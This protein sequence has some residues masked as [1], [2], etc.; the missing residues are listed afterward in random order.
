[1]SDHTPT[2]TELFFTTSTRDPAQ[3]DAMERGFFKAVRLSNGT[4]KTTNR[5]RLDDLNALVLEHLPSTRPL[6]AMDVAVSSG[7]SALEWLESMEEAGIDCRFTAG[8]AAVNAYLISTRSGLRALVDRNGHVLQ[9]EVRGKAVLPSRKRHVAMNIGAVI[10]LKI[11]ARMIAPTLRAAGEATEG[12]HGNLTW[13]KTQLVS[14]TL[15][16]RM[17]IAED[18][19][20]TNTRYDQC[21]DVL[22]A[23]NILN[24]AYFSVANLRR[25][26]TNL[27]NRLRPGGLLIICRTNTWRDGVDNENHGTLFRVLEDGRFEIVDRLGSGSELESLALEIPPRA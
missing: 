26:L 17:N 8:D 20:I 11:Y 27:R 15:I 2:A 16:G 5:R 21:F 14:R 9:Y 13:K 24:R 1:M 12:S 18:D 7:V 10:L 23:A 4:W 25:A 22:R 19:I 6:R 3:L